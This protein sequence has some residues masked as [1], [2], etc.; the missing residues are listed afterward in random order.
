MSNEQTPTVPVKS[1][2]L[3]GG[4]P[5]QEGEGKPAA[6]AA[7]PNV[8]KNVGPATARTRA[9]ILAI[10]REAKRLKNLALSQTQDAVPDTSPTTVSA[11][12]TPDTA[13]EPYPDIF[14]DFTAVSPKTKRAIFESLFGGLED[15]DE[16]KEPPPKKSKTT[17]EDNPKGTVATF[18]MDKTIDIAR[19]A[20]A[21]G[22]ISVGMVIFK[23]LVGNGPAPP[24]NSDN[25]WVK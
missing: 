5:T 12:A 8:D 24:A 4:K 19:L 14:P 17:T 7:T 3:G 22:A 25:S 9:D 2:N 13:P 15:E 20:A 18:I 11:T 23:N 21:S 6:A 1:I 16:S 10:A